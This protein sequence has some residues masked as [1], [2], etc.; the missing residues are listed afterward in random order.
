M[1]TRFFPG[2]PLGGGGYGRL[3]PLHS[4]PWAWL[5]WFDMAIF[6]ALSLAALALVIVLL[7]RLVRARRL[8]GRADPYWLRG[9]GAEQILA[10]RYARGEIDEGE[11]SRGIQVL[12]QGRA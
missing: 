11:Y 6:G 12:R 3:A 5:V 7:L 8:L 10:Q 2:R 1:L 9:P 4:G